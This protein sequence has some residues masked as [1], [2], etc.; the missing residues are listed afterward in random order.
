ML[1]P[2]EF[3]AALLT[4]SK[5]PRWALVAIAARSGLREPQLIAGRSAYYF[6]TTDHPILF[7]RLTLFDAVESAAASARRVSSQ[8]LAEAREK[9]IALSQRGSAP[10]ALGF[11]G[12]GIGIS[13]EGAAGTAMAAAMLENISEAKH[14]AIKSIGIS[15]AAARVLS[16]QQN[17][18]KD[19]EIAAR[20]SAS[21]RW[22]DGSPI[23]T[24]LFAV[25]SCFDTESS[26]GMKTILE[27]S[28]AVT[29]KLVEFLARHPQYL[30]TIPPP[31]FEKL[32]AELFRGFRFSIELHAR[33]GD[34]GIDI[35]AVRSDVSPSRYIIQCKRKGTEKVDVGVVRE[36]HGVVHDAPN[37]ESKGL[38]ATTSWLTKPAR[39]FV[40]RNPLWLDAA[41]YDRLVKWLTL[42][43]R[44]RFNP[45]SP[46][47]IFG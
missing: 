6:K 35:V 43:E 2:N 5:L 33:P 20:A 40:E 21:E 29:E 45:L 41:D 17:I 30:P 24:H 42:Y 11:S 32:I 19:I 9:M 12:P 47:A 31:V 22:T 15:F 16:T 8:T 1:G 4:L 23:P 13:S 14:A 28:D 27:V 26:I 36:L 38:I 34:G 3:R 10:F 7:E 46:E 37:Q 39:E 18:L 25:F 44:S